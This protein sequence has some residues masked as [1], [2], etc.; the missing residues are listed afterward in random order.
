[1]IC[2]LLKGLLYGGSSNKVPLSSWKPSW[3]RHLCWSCLNSA[4]HSKCIV[5]HLWWV[6][7]LSYRRSNALWQFSARN[8]PPQKLGTMLRT[9]SLWPSSRLLWSGVSIYMATSV[10]YIL[11]TSLYI[12]TYVHIHVTSS[13][14]SP[15]LLAG[16][17]G[18]I[19]LVN[20]V[21]AWGENIAA[22]VL[23]RFGQLFE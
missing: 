3:L 9:G 16:A 4:S 8:S 17:L 22:D 7:V 18:R 13:K 1:M 23:S 11:T 2:C 14:H 19:G 21:Q 15:G 6:W 10:P 12:Y 20:C 5:M